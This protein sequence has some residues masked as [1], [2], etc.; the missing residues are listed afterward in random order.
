MAEDLQ[1]ETLVETTEVLEAQDG[2]DN[3]VVPT[4]KNDDEGP[5]HDEKSDWQELMGKDLLLKVIENCFLC[6]L[7]TSVFFSACG[8][9]HSTYTSPCLL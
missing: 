1:T 5:L 8:T 2:V 3:D 9:G 7:L 4:Q 6:V